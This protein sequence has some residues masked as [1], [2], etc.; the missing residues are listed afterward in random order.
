MTGGIDGETLRVHGWLSMTHSGKPSSDR[1]KP[2]AGTVSA[3][4]VAEGLGVSISTVSRAFQPG[5]GVAPATRARVLAR[6]RAL[7]YQPNP[8]A[9]TLITQRTRIVSVFISDIFNPFFPEALTT[10]TEALQRH[11]LSVMLFHVPLGLTPDEVLPQALLYKPECVIV[12]TATL[13]FQNAMAAAE[14]GSHLIFFNRYVPQSNTFSITCDNERGGREVAD[15]LL[16]TGHSN[17]AYV[18]GT[19]D[20][21]TSIDRGRGFVVRCAEAGITVAQ[22]NMARVFSYE[23][24]YAAAQRLLAAIPDLDGI[25][26]ANDIVAIGAIDGLRHELGLDV[27]GDISVVGFDDVSM[28]AW[29]SH[30]LTTYRHPVRRMAAATVELIKEIETDPGLAPVARRIA[31]ELVLRGTHRSR[32]KAAALEGR[33]P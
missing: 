9:R 2:F 1:S 32:G 12:M 18:A 10:L 7:G 24:G 11:G 21:T 19:P 31:G 20:A 5:S 23:D 16:H 3:R 27:P 14:A 30:A 33:R 29:P 17:M 13:S 28:A 15:F 8:Y 25:F 6:A 26:C 4:E 22:D